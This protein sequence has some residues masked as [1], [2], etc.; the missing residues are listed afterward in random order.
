MLNKCENTWVAYWER[1]ERGH[2]DSS[3]KTTNK[4]SPKKLRLLHCGID[5]Y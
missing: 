2:E 1:K 4:M 3:P 5:G